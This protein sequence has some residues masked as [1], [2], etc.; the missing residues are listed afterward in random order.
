MNEV[1]R[2]ILENQRCIMKSIG[3]WEATDKLTMEQI[4][5]QCIKVDQA[6][7]PNNKDFEFKHSLSE[8]QTQKGTLPKEEKR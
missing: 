4:I 7:A 6:L 3:D 5:E 8:P 2:L 1:E